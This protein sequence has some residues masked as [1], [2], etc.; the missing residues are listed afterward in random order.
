MHAGGISLLSAVSMDPRY[1]YLLINLGSI[2]VPFIAS[3]E[4]RL[5]FYRQWKAL[6]PALLITL[7]FFIVWDHYLAA[8]DVW[9]FNPKYVLG[10]YWWGCRWKNGFFFITIPY[11]CLFIYASLN[12]LLPREPFSRH[13][14]NITGAWVVILLFVA[15]LGYDRLYTGIKLTLT[16]VL[17]AYAWYRDYAWMGNSSAATSSV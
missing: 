6:L 17:L 12:Y 9:G 7:V 10:I 8:W 1:T 15:A 16:A 11:S 2:L 3:F 4:P 5:R 14:R 13:A